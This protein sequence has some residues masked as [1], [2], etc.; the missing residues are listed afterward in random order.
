MSFEIFHLSLPAGEP[1]N[2]DSINLGRFLRAMTN[3][4]K[5]KMKLFAQFVIY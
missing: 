3:L 1:P 4:G 5:W 2:Q